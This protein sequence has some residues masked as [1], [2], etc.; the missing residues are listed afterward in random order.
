MHIAPLPAREYYREQV[1]E[2]RSLH[3]FRHRR[4]SVRFGMCLNQHIAANRSS[5]R[6]QLSIVARRKTTLRDL[7]YLVNAPIRPKPASKRRDA[8]AMVKGSIGEH[9]QADGH[10][11]TIF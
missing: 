8:A 2:S 3:E 6:H 4:G 5:E 7:G 1:I 11:Y 10:I 9:G